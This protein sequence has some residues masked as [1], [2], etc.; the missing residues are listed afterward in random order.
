[1]PGSDLDVEA[2]RRA[3]IDWQPN[4]EDQPFDITSPT[5]REYNCAAWGAEETSRKWDPTAIGL[6]GQIMP[7]Y[8]WPPG[9]PVFATTRALEEA[10]ATLGYSPCDNGDAVPGVQKLVIYGERGEWKHVARQ[11]ASG[12]WTS[13]MGDLADIEHDDESAIEDGLWIGDVES[14]LSRPIPQKTL[15]PAPKRLVLPPG[16]PP[17]AGM[18]DRLV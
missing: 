16:I 15:P 3:L 5:S 4:L 12:R 14:Y 11:T 7:P 13:K 10:Y 8:Y 1:L 18:A 6:D 2:E 9:V 17:G